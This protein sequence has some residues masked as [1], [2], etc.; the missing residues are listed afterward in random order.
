MNPNGILK[1]RQGCRAG[2]AI[3][4]DAGGDSRRDIGRARVV[5]YDEIDNARAVGAALVGAA[6]SHPRARCRVDEG[7]RS[8]AASPA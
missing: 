1:K 4:H 6:S 7:R 8:G 5:A 2:L 3:A